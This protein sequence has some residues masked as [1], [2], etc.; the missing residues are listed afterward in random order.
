MPFKS[1][2]QM[3]LFFAKE[4]RGEL[5]RGTARKWAEHTPSIKKL[6]EQV[7]R[8][9]VVGFEKVAVLDLS[10]EARYG[11]LVPMQDYV[12]GQNLD[13]GT[14]QRRKGNLRTENVRN[15]DREFSP[16]IK[17]DVENARVPKVKG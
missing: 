7:K 6:P 9:F 1:K 3:R 12:P 4:H 15:E 2:A 16:A 5:P 11:A 17:H 13:K 14:G 10:E 8:A